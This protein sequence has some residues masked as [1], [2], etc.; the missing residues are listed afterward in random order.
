MHPLGE[1][2]GAKAKTLDVSVGDVPA[3]CRH[4]AGEAVG[5]APRAQ[6]EAC[7]PPDAGESTTSAPSAKRCGGA[8][9]VAAHLVAEAPK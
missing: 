7:R 5:L 3:E 2:G 1:R 9:V 8:L 4:A 6:V